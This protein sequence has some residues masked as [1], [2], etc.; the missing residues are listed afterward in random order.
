MENPELR[1]SK[2][3]DFETERLRKSYPSEDVVFPLIEITRSIDY[4]HFVL[5]H[6]EDESSDF[7]LEK[8]K[9][10]WGKSFSEFYKDLDFS[11]EIPLFRFHQSERDWVDSILQHAGNIG[12]CE[13]L[14]HYC[15]AD[16]LSLREDLDSF[17][18]THIHERGG[19][20]YFERRSLAYYHSLVGKILENKSKS[21]KNQ[22]DHV[23]LQLEKTVSVLHD[24]FIQYKATPEID[25][26]Y[27]DFAYVHLMTTQVIDDFGEDDLFGGIAYGKY[28]DFVE[29]LFKA[30]IM[31][32][33]FC[34]AAEKKN[35]SQV[36]LRD[37]LTYVFS[38]DIFIKN[39]SEYTGWSTSETLQILS[40]F[41]LDKSNIDYH[42]SYPLA[43]APPYIKLGSDT[44][45]RSAYGSIERPTF[46]LN[47]ELKRR[48][49][50]DYFKAVNNREKRFRDQLYSLFSQDKIVRIED[51][52][53]IK[54]GDLVTDIDAVLYD[55]ECH[56]LGLFQLKWQDTFSS[57]MKER[58]SRISNL[59]PKSVD[60]ID[61]IEHWLHNNEANT[62]AN[63]LK[64]EP[65]IDDFK[66]IYLFVLSR[67][68]VH[69]TNQELDSRAIWASWYQLFEVTS[70]V[71]AL[72]EF[73][74]I[75][76]LAA[77]LKFFNPQNKVVQDRLPKFKNIEFKFAKYKVLVLPQNSI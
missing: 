4:H 20:E 66:E 18:F 28:L 45:L 11:D 70:R 57:S 71:R 14:L 65:K 74:P 48:Y 30:V 54:S 38:K 27:K 10:G 56:V 22:L 75:G 61:K 26:F 34:M 33:D 60:W 42:L 24:N 1:L 3:L 49:P 50:K 16:L 69:F 6:L 52:I 77:K 31:H 72:K 59:L 39:F 35:P 9:F 19:I 2:I 67:N 8:Y 46:F 15:K 37:I 25:Q 29:E 12:L 5:S 32:R 68:H 23:K 17:I 41:T 7:L 13:Q 40:C 62:I 53:I 55:K 64:L 76:E 58:F 36:F 51:N 21:I 47:R 73:N 44:L 43:S 63:T